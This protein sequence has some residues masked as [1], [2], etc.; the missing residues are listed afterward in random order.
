MFNRTYGGERLHEVLGNA[1]KVLV[2]LYTGE[3]P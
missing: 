3:K 1:R 2:D